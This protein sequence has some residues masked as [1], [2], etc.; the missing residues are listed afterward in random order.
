MGVIPTFNDLK[1]PF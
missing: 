1:S